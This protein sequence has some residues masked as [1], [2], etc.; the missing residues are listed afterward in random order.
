MSVEERPQSDVDVEGDAASNGGFSDNRLGDEKV[1][2]LEDQLRRVL[3]DLDNLRKR[4]AREA[5]RERESERQR[6]MLEWL[7]I[8][9]N[10]ERAIEHAGGDTDAV[11]EGVKAVRDQAVAVLTRLGFPRFDDIGEKFDPLRHEVV[12]AIEQED[13]APNSIVAVVRPG[14]G[15]EGDILRPAGVVVAKG[16]H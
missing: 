16:K 2:E 8:V 4:Y 13:A 3:A 6:V 10:L 15:T 12:T 7:P 1:A 11:A 5:G 14:Y 9:D